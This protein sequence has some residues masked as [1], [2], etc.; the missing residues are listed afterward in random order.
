MT[1]FNSE[2]YWESRLKKETGSKGVG[3][4]GL[5]THYNNWL[6][7]I[8]EHLFRRH[9]AGLTADWS[10]KNVLDIG[11]G[12]GF[13]LEQWKKLG[14]RSIT[15]SD[16]TDAAL[17]NIAKKFPGIESHKFSAGKAIPETLCRNRY[18]AI[19]AIAVLFHIVD[20]AEYR[21]AF[22]NISRLL[23]PDGFFIFTENFL[24]RKTYRQAHFV[25]RPLREIEGIL[26]ENGLKVLLRK[27]MFVLSN[28]PTDTPDS[29]PLRKYWEIMMLPVRKSELYGLIFGGIMYA[30]ELFLTSI[31]DESPSAEIMVCV[32]I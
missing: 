4:I 3:F 1:Q 6:Y 13:Y 27:P 16:M 7:K 17:E 14:V 8:Q 26:E 9:V 29:L 15:A 22:N 32:K 24:H 12:T 25:G 23:R 19:S 30:A 21:M 10:Q 18:D 31:I 2:Q 28:Y 5:G 11:S 20:D